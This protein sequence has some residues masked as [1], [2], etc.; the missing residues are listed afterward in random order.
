[1]ADRAKHLAAVRLDEMHG[2]LFLRNASG[3]VAC[4]E[5]PGIVALPDRRLGGDVSERVT[6]KRPVDQILRAVFSCEIRTGSDRR[7]QNLVT[8]LRKFSH[9]ERDR[10]CR[11]I[12]HHAHVLIVEPLTYD[13]G[14]DVWLILMVR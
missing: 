12:D 8:L 5:K 11:E 10:G 2:V 3:I 13:I 1:M 14:S 9:R 7:D 6:V 4:Q